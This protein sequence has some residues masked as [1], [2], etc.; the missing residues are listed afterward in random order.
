MCNKYN[1]QLV[2]DP[3]QGIARKI[4]DANIMRSDQ[5]NR[6]KTQIVKHLPV[7]HTAFKSDYKKYE[8]SKF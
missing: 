1:E 7:L 3:F 2:A 8:K 6:N 4:I 5:A